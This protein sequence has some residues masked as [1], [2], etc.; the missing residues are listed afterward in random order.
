MG[1]GIAQNTKDG[2]AAGSTGR[3]D[4]RDAQGLR[5]KG[6]DVDEKVDGVLVERPRI[7]RKDFHFSDNVAGEQ[8][9]NII[10]VRLVAVRRHFQRVDFRY[11]TFDA[12]YIRNC[13]FDSCDF[14]GCRFTA[15]NFSGTGFSGCIFDYAIF[16][17][18]D[19]DSDILQTG[20]PSHENLAMRFARSLRLNFQQIGDVDA[21]NRAI[22]VELDATK[23]HLKKA[24]QGRTSYHRMKYRGWTRVGYFF[25]WLNFRV[26]EVIWGNGESLLRL[27]VSFLVFLGLIA[28]AEMAKGA[29][30]ASALVDAPQVF[31]ALGNPSSFSATSMAAIL[32]TRLVFFSMFTSTLIKKLSRR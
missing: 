32:A 29:S 5:S 26:F 27:S 10:F 12:S 31:F 25:R 9:R 6:D 22:K 15:S 13:T 16:E 23:V 21:V 3:Q 17:K 4:S 19:I 30:I 24:W 28:V 11:S 20:C 14:T 18:T 2:R 1:S 8:Y 7:E